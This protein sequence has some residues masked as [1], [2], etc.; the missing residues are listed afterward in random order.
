EKLVGVVEQPWIAR[1]KEKRKGPG[2]PVL[3][4]KGE[5][6]IDALLLKRPL[7][8]TPDRTAKENLRIGGIGRDVAVLSAG[9]H[10][11]P[12]AQGDGRKFRAGEGRDGSA[13]LLRSVDPVGKPLVGRDMVELRGRLVVPGAPGLRPI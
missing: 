13:V 2:V 8:E 1:G 9:R 7:V 12:V 4:G 10:R 11:P 6:G 3:S 5:R